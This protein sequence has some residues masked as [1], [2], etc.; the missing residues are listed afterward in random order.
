MQPLISRSKEKKLRR[1]RPLASAPLDE[2]VA[3][4]AKSKAQP[5]D[6]VRT[7]FQD[8]EN[9]L[10]QET[11]ILGQTPPGDFE[12]EEDAKDDKDKADP[13]LTSTSTLETDKHKADPSLTSTS[14]VETDKHKADASLTSTSPKENETGKHGKEKENPGPSL[15][16][17][18][19][20]ETDK[21]KSGTPLTPTSTVEID[22][23][24]GGTALASTS[25]VD[26]DKH[27]DGTPLASTSSVKIDE[28]KGGPT[29]T[30]T[31]TPPS[32]VETP[33]VKGTKGTLKDGT[34]VETETGKGGKNGTPL[35]SME[36]KTR[37]HPQK[38]KEQ[39]EEKGK[40]N[41]KKKK[42][43]RGGKINRKK[44][45]N[46]RKT[47]AAIKEKGS[48]KAKDGTRKKQTKEEKR[49]V[50]RAACKRWHEKWVK[51]GVPRTSDTQEATQEAK[52][53][54]KASDL[55]DNVVLALTLDKME[56][57]TPQT[58]DLRTTKATFVN[59]FVEKLTEKETKLLAEDPN[60][61][62][63]TKS[64]KYKKGVTA[65]MNSALRGALMSGKN[66]GYASVPA[67]VL[68]G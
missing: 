53:T 58:N 22:E 10:S 43:A 25:T 63:L 68:A 1:L 17:T 14:T 35:A 66:Q 67:S 30:S 11:L 31:A 13:S 51:K 40:L 54:K 65:W 2:H 41:S 36:K 56:H 12:D 34:A 44:R 20:V 48:K 52:K 28:R 19:T 9:V 59:A 47:L 38:K 16:S 3:T 23:R 64:E 45:N 26:T 46:G 8:E 60:A 6:T 50:H 32:P 7:L 37:K 33:T 21:H 42:D 27:K 61:G 49:A 18:S 24:K 55:P 62:M 29:L 39:P 15:T 5:Q 57:I 4:A